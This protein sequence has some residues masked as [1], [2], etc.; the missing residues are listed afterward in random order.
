MVKNLRAEM[1][2]ESFRKFKGLLYELDAD[3]NDEALERLIEIY[4]ANQTLLEVIGAED[5]L[6]ALTELNQNWEKSNES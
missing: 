1:E 5:N 6:E 2:D 4:E 3:T